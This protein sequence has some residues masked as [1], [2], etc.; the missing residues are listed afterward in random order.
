MINEAKCDIFLQHIEENKKSKII[1]DVLLGTLSFIVPFIILWVLF[2]ANGF[3]PFVEGG[4][5]IVSFDMQSEY[6]AYMRYFKSIL[7]GDYS[8]IFTEGK[9]FGGDFLSIYT[10]YLA[11]PLNF[12]VVFFSDAAI[13]D[14][15]LITSMIKMCLSSLTFYFLIRFTTGHSKVGNLVFS[16]GYG[17]VSYSLIY[18][19]NY[20]WLD[21]VA[22]LPLVVLGLEQ[23]KKGKALYLYP[24]AIALTLISSWYTGFIV[25][26]FAATLII[27][28]FFTMDKESHQRFPFLLRAVVFSL[29]GGFL[30]SFAWVTAYFHFSGTKAFVDLPK[31]EFFSFSML[32]SGF[33]ENGYASSHEIQQYRGYISMFTGVV[34]LVFFL[35]YFLNEKYSRRER[36]SS[37]G[38]CFFY[39]LVIL[40]SFLTAMFHGG[41]EPTWFPGRYSFIIGFLVCYFAYKDY[42][43]P[44]G[45]T[46]YSLIPLILAPMIVLP[47]VIYTKNSNY[48][49]NTYEAL[50]YVLSVPSLLIYIATV[51][52]VSI[53]PLLKDFAFMQAHHRTYKAF[54]GVVLVPLT[55]LSSYRGYSKIIQ[56]NQAENIYQD[57]EEYLEDDA[58]SPLFEDLKAYD[59]QN[60]YRME[61][62]FNRPGNYNEIN[63][64]PMFYRY[65]GLNHFSSCEKKDVEAFFEK[66]GFHY[67]YFFERYD[68]G[69]TATINSLLNMKYLIDDDKKKTDEPVFMRNPSSDNPWKKMTDLTPR[70]EGY[71]YYQ[72]TNVLPYAFFVQNSNA[73]YYG[74][75]YH[76]Q[77]PVTGEKKTYWYDSFEFQNNYVK[78]MVKLP[79]DKD[80][81]YE[82]PLTL[83]ENDKVTYTKDENGYYTISCPKGTTLSF[84][85]TID[86]KYNNG[87]FYFDIKDSDKNLSSRLDG[88]YY[89]NSTYWHKGIRGFI[90]DS[91]TTHTLNITTTTA[92]TNYKFRPSVAYEDLS[93]MNEYIDSLQENALENFS[94]KND[95][96]SASYQGEI[97][98]PNSNFDR[99]LLFTLPNEKNVSISV[100]GKKQEVI[101]R[102]NIFAAVRIKGFESGKHTISFTYTDKGLIAGSVISSIACITLVLACIYYPRL[103]KKIFKKKED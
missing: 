89:E 36:I 4:K 21:A 35:R 88:V 65:N 79:E 50:H 7:Q 71:S 55:C 10:F 98:I 33:L 37:F 25:C 29:L 64:N 12:F 95:L 1:T 16:V 67:N 61:A 13:P 54:V 101:T 77:D 91:R 83:K 97:N 85:F 9:V 47:V 30:A 45:N 27:Y 82:I 42:D 32:F 57:K 5:T 40:N 31:F 68:G 14:F 62:T 26:I 99:T 46:V 90:P 78:S 53:Y 52:I 92:R 86:A 23:L 87:N 102:G 17:L 70:L 49:D 96:F 24:L 43:Q 18:I 81:F 72:N 3:S 48:Y 80:I 76:Y 44:E 60:D 63:N 69:S 6:V 84:T 41:K 59:K 2:S 103:E 8:Y 38:L 100:D 51:I 93:I 56:V 22:I 15:F 34:S 75:G 73:E 58:L 94:R 19:S 74:D 39:V 20:M 28:Y 66:L 11:S